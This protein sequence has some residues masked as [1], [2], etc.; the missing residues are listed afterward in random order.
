[1]LN[2]RE[3]SFIIILSA[4]GGAI[5]VPIG[6]AGNLL[7]AIP[8]LPLGTS[9]LLSGIHILW[10]ILAALLTKKNGAATLT[11]AVKGLVELTLFSFHGIQVLL[12]SLTEGIIVDTTLRVLGTDSP[13]KAGVAGGLSASSNVLVMWLLVLYSLPH[14]VIAFMWLL[15]LASGFTVG[16]FGEY[17]SKRGEK[18]YR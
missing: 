11:G 16:Y 5:S 14:T 9:Q 7:K 17:A 12:I 2:T 4:L 6:Y 1:M 10:P 18:I 8:I 3:L 13:I 15:S